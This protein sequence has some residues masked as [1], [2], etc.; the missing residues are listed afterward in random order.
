MINIKKS[1]FTSIKDKIGKL[2]KLADNNTIAFK[3]ILYLIILDDLLDWAEYLDEAQD[4]QDKLKNLRISFTLNNKDAII[5]I[6]DSCESRM[7]VNVNL[8]Q[9]NNTWSRVFDEDPLVIG[10]ADVYC[11]VEDP[12]YV[13]QEVTLP[14]YKNNTLLIYLDADDK[15]TCSDLSQLTVHEKMNYYLDD[16]ARQWVLDPKT[17]KF[18]QTDS[19]MTDD[20]IE[21]IVTMVIERLPQIPQNVSI[22]Y[23]GG[24][25]EAAKFSLSEEEGNDT[26]DIMDVS[27]LNF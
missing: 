11:F 15:V 26:L 4:V 22:T 7:Y 19:S 12:S 13:R 16:K 8:P 5:P 1:I 14:Y 25:D 17:C 21:R 2:Q 23:N 9:T 18:Q 10:S 20:Q 24:Q 27:D 6:Y 3:K